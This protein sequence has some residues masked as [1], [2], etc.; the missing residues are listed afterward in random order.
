[1]GGTFDFAKMIV[2]KHAECTSI[3][4]FSWLDSFQY[5]NRKENGAVTK[6]LMYN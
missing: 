2:D 6:A 1:L 5:L 3:P 4:Y